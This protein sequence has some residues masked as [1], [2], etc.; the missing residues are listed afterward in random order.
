MVRL[1][2]PFVI[3]SKRKARDFQALKRKVLVKSDG[4]KAPSSSSVWFTIQLTIQ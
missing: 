4:I 2:V 3:R 1:N